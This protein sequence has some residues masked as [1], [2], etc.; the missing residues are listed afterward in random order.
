[1]KPSRSIPWAIRQVVQNG[2]Q[3]DDMPLITGLEREGAVIPL[4]VEDIPN[5]ADPGLHFVGQPTRQG[6]VRRGFVQ[7]HHQQRALAKPLR[8]RLFSAGQELNHSPLAT[9]HQGIVQCPE[10]PL[11]GSS[12]LG[13]RLALPFLRSGL[14]LCL[15][16]RLRSRLRPLEKN[17]LLS[18]PLL[19]VL[20]GDP[21]TSLPIAELEVRANLRKSKNGQANL[22][23]KLKNDASETAK[24]GKKRQGVA[25][26][27][28]EAS[29][30]T[31]TLWQLGGT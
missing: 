1:M 3:Q 4:P 28:E 17:S 10:Q 31:T 2:C 27:V 26:H 16:F 21:L 19:R 8:I 6:K 20:N 14:G 18:V 13:G 5:N 23:N 25:R 15:G 9:M 7:V 29:P 12:L 24:D 22:R 11:R 30:G